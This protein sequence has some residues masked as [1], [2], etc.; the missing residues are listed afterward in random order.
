MI[1]FA[2]EGLFIEAEQKL[3]NQG[4]QLSKEEWQRNTT[5]FTYPSYG[6]DP[7]LAKNRDR[8]T[9]RVL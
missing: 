1:P 9:R 2:D 6:F 5:S 4:M 3:F 8:K 7:N